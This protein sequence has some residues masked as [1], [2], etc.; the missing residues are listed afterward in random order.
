[1]SV[2]QVNDYSNPAARAHVATVN[3]SE[4]VRQL[5]VTAAAAAG[6]QAGARA[7]EVAHYRTCLASALV[8]SCGSDTFRSALRTLG[9][10]GV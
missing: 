4:G 5:A 8:N 2:L 1:M 10:G 7:A 3:A 6:N 9:A